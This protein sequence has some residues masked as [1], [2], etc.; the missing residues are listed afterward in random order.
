MVAYKVK[1]IRTADLSWSGAT[2]SVDVRRNGAV[3]VTTANDGLFTDTIGGKGGGTYT[4]RVC[5]AGTT[6]CS[7]EVTVGF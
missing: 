3:V 1:G 4:Y 2:S 5:Q 7:P 6:T